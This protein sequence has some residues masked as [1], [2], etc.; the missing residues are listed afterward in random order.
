M[1]IQPQNSLLHIGLCMWENEVQD[2]LPVGTL[3]Y[4]NNPGQRLGFVGFAYD[5]TY[6][7]EGWP[8]VDPAHL[9]PQVN[10][11][12]FV[13]KHRDGRLPHYFASFLPGEFGQ[14]LLNEVDQRWEGLTEAKKLYVMTL[15]HGD[16]GAPQLN[17]QNDQYNEPIRDLSD[18]NRLVTA[19]REFQRG[20]RS[21]P[22]TRE[23]QGALCSLRGPK[24]KVDYEY[25]KDSIARRYVAK[26]NTTGYFNDARVAVALADMEKNSGIRTCDNRVVALECGEEVLFS[27]NYSR[28]EA[29]DQNDAG[30]KYRLILKYNRI[31]FKTLLAEDP[32]LGNTQRPS[33]K[34]LVY[35][36]NKYSADAVTDRE[37]LYR[38]AVFTAATNHTS[39]G[40]D[41][42]EM[43][44]SGRGRWRLSPSFHNLPNPLSDTQFET[45]FGDT[46]M[47]GNLLRLNEQFLTSLG[48]HFGFDAL[49]AQALAF[50]VT[51]SLTHMESVMAKH[52][53]STNDR[54]TLRE[55]VKTRAVTDLH[56][57]LTNNTQV[58]QRAMQISNAKT[59]VDLETNAI[60]LIR[61]PSR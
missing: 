6:V 53:L 42:L 44:D 17:S 13:G 18:L 37:E 14:Q 31:S 52:D 29:F 49:H 2:Y 3:F 60:S 23:L 61:G 40:L 25:E 5:R 20:E 7:R 39:N 35:T 27:H 58:Q 26:L 22:L 19:I 30:D 4:D 56:S 11:G 55:C 10:D 21:S 48:A 8:A 15:A 45:S 34:H 1:N 12:R 46:I 28:T 9:N 41:N 59:A 43:Y 32:V 50:P 57:R 54:N 38:R 33:Y 24:P 47:T 16:F 36:I 51:E